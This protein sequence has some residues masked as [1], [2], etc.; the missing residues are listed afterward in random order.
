MKKDLEE[1]KPICIKCKKAMKAV[2]IKLGKVNAR[3]W[4]CSKCGEEILH[5]LD[6]E[7][8][9]LMAKLKKGIKL[10][11]GILNKA[12]YVRFPKGFS[13][14]LRKGETVSLTAKAPG[15]FFIEIGSRIR[16]K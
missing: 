1:G 11:V 8:A 13:K 16:T 5:P 6:A 14:L 2:Q 7:K 4:R 3:A 12:P 15:Q 9:L 10:K